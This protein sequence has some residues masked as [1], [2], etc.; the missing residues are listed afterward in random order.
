MSRVALLP[1]SYPPSLGG[2]EELTRHL[3]LALA[4]AGDQVEVWTG[5]PDDGVPETVE[6]LDGLVVRR[7]PM[8]L[9]A[10][11]WPALRRTAFTGTRTLR[12]LRSA[13]AAFRPDV[14]HV[15]CFG[16]N[17]AYATA[18][19]RVTGLPL[20]V[21]LQGET[22]M[23]DV[24]I[25]DTSR[26]LRAALRRGLRSAE[27]VTG[28][29]AFTLA[30]A[31]ERFGL[32]PRRGQVIP[33]GVDLA[34]DRLVDPPPRPS[35]VGTDRPYILALGRVVEK[36]GFDLLLSAFAAIDEDR[37]TADV[38]IA[39]VGPA[40]DGLRRLADDLGISA[41]VHFA[42]RLDRDRVA[43]AMA[44]AT[45]FV[46]PSRLE[47]FGIVILEGWRSGT[48]V[49][50]TSRG[51]PSEFVRDGE[52]GVLV[53]PFDADRFAAALDGLLSDPDR[54]EAIAEAGRARVQ[55]FGW[56]SIAEAYRGVYA[57]VVHP[58]DRSDGPLPGTAPTPQ[59][60]SVA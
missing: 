23:D 32:E 54:R 15:Q 17:G 6:V 49:V 24:D 12:S 58:G 46:V 55:D 2:V 14:L 44:G 1:S 43:A 27:A 37:R 48:A 36:K 34:P 4:D 8:P 18:L 20:V 40:L 51:G 28:C 22:L 16:P 50:A 53:D 45:L 38:V 9:P 52:D 60:E 41:Q 39:G 35:E 42:G 26:V 30:D 10:T 11:N 7:L 5:Q 33:N 47:P 59:G 25:F 56:P 57:A 31:E 3:A 29:S 13:V 19:A 21:T